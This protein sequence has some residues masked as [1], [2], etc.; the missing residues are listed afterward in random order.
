MIGGFALINWAGHFAVYIFIVGLTVASFAEIQRLFTDRARKQAVPEENRLL[1]WYWFAVASIFINGRL[2]IRHF[3]YELIQRSD[4]AADVVRYFYV[5]ALMAGVAGI[6]MFVLTL[7]KTFYMLQFKQFGWTIVALAIAVTQ[8]SFWGSNALSG[9]FWLFF[10]A[11]CVVCNDC[12]AYIFGFFFGKTPLIKL[13]PKKTW[14]GFIGGAVSTLLWAWAAAHFLAHFDYM[15]CPK[16]TLDT[17]P[18]DGC[19]RH[20][21]FVLTTYAAPP[22]FAQAISLLHID[23]LMPFLSTFLT[24]PWRI[25]PIQLHAI[26]FGLFAS[27]IAPFGGFFASGFKRALK[28][29]DFSDTI[30]GH[31]GIVDRF[32]CQ[33]MMGTFTFVY[34]STFIPSATSVSSIL[35]QAASLTADQQIELAHQLAMMVESAAGRR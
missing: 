21:V 24:S 3:G 14:E 25:Y 31:G 26:F 33:F 1:A 28:I 11:S 7:K 35:A 5:Y 32:D 30:P 20:P 4:A 16:D 12:T 22:I 10:P 18:E 2:L 27:L 15:V 23:T 34:V 19:T 6:V 13:S 17:H 9:L 29:K 8:A